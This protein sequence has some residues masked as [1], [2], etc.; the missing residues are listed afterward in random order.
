MLEEQERT[1]RWP[2]L[3]Y[4][5][6]ADTKETLH[7][8]CQVIGKTRL[9]LEPMVNH[10]WQVPLYVSARGLTTSA[11][12]YGGR[13][14]LD[15]ELDFLERQLVL[16]TSEGGLRRLPLG[17][18]AV[19]DFYAD[20][21]AALA[22]LGVEARI[23]PVPV[24]MADA[25]PFAQDHV[26]AAYDAAAAVKFWRV[27]V[28]V[29]R[30]LR[31]FRGRFLGKV[32]P[33]HF[34][35][36]SFDVAVTRFSGRP[37]P[38]HPGGA[39]HVADWVMREAYSHEVSSAGFWPGGPQADAMFYSYAYPI[40]EGFSAAPVRPAGAYYHHELGEFVLPY[41][42]LRAEPDPDA[43]LLDFLQS[44]YEAAATLAGWDRAALERP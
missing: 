3:R 29:E 40:P 36:G 43:A 9:A 28:Q 33:V 38:P 41:E 32:S 19:A 5:E 17:P 6:W 31:I 16:R 20:Y 25:L 10:W 26:H 39:P 7:R 13:A 15:A 8:Y 23:W 34:F 35:W 12:P 44:T 22:E 14:V 37:A 11:I 18:H 1:E 30:I 21:R 24:E 27:L 2:A 42:A 4:A